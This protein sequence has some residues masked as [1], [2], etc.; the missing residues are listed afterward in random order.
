VRPR[1]PF[2]AVA[3]AALACATPAAASAAG[4]DLVGT[5]HVLV[6]YKDEAAHNPD[7]ERWEDRVWVFAREG[8]RLR[9]T[10]YPLVVLSDE[11]GRFER[12]GTNRASRRLVYWTPT[13]EQQ[14]ELAK[15][16]KVN[17]RGSKSKALRTA[18]EGWV[19]T[20]AHPPSAGFITYE[21][22]WSVTGGA[23]RPVFTR[24]DSL[25]GAMAGDTEGRT[26][27]ETTEVDPGSGALRGRYDRDGQRR[28]TFVMTRVGA[29][30]M[31][32][33]KSEEEQRERLREHMLDQ[34]GRDLGAEEE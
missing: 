12:L 9:W 2:A 10:D 18:P 11:S 7:A 8:E 24:T 22:H 13:P 1:G 31:L 21:E 14:A 29:V 34:F 25:T 30:Q 27:Y 20:N 32:T 23:E 28:G 16:P 6:H 15:G 26:L 3:A 4:V 17:S 5:W 33:P 19:S